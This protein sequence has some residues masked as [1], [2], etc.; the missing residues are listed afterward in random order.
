MDGEGVFLSPDGYVE[1]A[2]AGDGDGRPFISRPCDG[3][4]EESA[5]VV[6]HDFPERAVDVPREVDDS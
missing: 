4:S 3:V 1:D 5:V 6:V 2:R